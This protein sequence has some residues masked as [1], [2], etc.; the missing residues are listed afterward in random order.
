M[1]LAL[2]MERSYAPYTKWLGTAFS[3]LGHPDGLDRDLED[4]LKAGPF[5]ERER[6]LT[7]AYR[8]AAIRFNALRLAEPVDVE[9]HQ[10]HE[11]PAIVLGAERFVQASLEAVKDQKVRE[12]GLVGAID[13]FADN[14]E[15]LSNPLAYRKL[16]SIYE[17]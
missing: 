12:L 9:P 16:I 7:S 11:R 2:L 4:T 1:R 3:Q 13:Q 6:A 17:K 14:T 15:V 10:F 8:K 5:A